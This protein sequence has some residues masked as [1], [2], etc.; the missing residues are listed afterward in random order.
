MKKYITVYLI[1]FSCL[2]WS[3]E[4]I[5]PKYIYEKDLN[6][7]TIEQTEDINLFRYKQIQY[8][9]QPEKKITLSYTGIEWYSEILKKNYRNKDFIAL[10]QEFN[11]RQYKDLRIFVDTSQKTP[12]IKTYTDTTKISN[13]DYDIKMDSLAAGLKLSK[14]IP[15]IITYYDGFPVTIYNMEE[16][17]RII[18]FGNNVILEL[19]GLDKNHQ[20][21]KIDGFRKY[22][23]GVGIKFF[24]L[25]S[26]EIAT[27]FEPRLTGNFKTKF[28]YRL[29][30]ILSN[31]FDGSINDK[32]FEQID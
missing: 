19:E 16:R 27:V 2:L 28:R 30:N 21:K 12:L 20:W 32:Y 7:I 1:L 29:G 13:L 14:E 22:T 9:G 10:N 31:E 11:K 25:K 5:Y 8:I 3:Q 26:K 6:N 17:E 23:C 4:I 18:G 15:F 24:V